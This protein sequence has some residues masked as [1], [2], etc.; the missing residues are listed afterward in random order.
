MYKSFFGLK[1]NPFELSPDPF[2]VLVTEKMKEALFSLYYAIAQRKGFVVLTG[3]VGTGKTLMVQCLLLLLKQQKVRFSNVFNPRLS[4]L[5]FLHFVV[6]DLGIDVAEPTK[7]N[8]LHALCRFVLAEAEKGLTTVLIIDEAQQLPTSVMEELRLLTN[9]ETT[10]HKLL[11]V[12]LIG[13]PELDVKLD[14]Y[15]LRQLK[16]RIAV[17]CRL[18]PL[19]ENDVRLYMEHR[20]QLA[21]LSGHSSIFPSETV[22]AIFRYSSGLPRIVNTLCDQ[23]LL[24][25]F[26]R[27]SQVVLPEIIDEIAAYFRLQPI[28][29]LVEPDRSRNGGNVGQPIT[30]KSF[31]QTDL[32]RM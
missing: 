28:P 6:R 3:E 21:G 25:A 23:G 9:L 16:Q 18:E 2:F 30:A 5:D 7:A 17:R 22:S 10:Q 14:S 20:L 31:V 4:P 24:A 26:A 1:R 13:Q 27:G 11:Q 8:L 29:T 12:I 32:R 19:C 15:E